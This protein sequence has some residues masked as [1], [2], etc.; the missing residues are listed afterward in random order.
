M[1]LPPN[2]TKSF[3]YDLE[4]EECRSDIRQDRLPLLRSPWCVHHT[5]LTKDVCEILQVF[6]LSASS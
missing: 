6:F 4:Q 1:F 2:H 3:S 5:I